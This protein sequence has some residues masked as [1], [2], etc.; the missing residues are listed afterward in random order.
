MSLIHE[1]TPALKG[2]L[3]QNDPKH[4]LDRVPD[5]FTQGRLQAE[6]H[7][8]NGSAFRGTQTRLHTAGA[9]SLNPTASERGAQIRNSYSTTRPIQRTVWWVRLHA[10]E[11]SSDVRGTV[12]FGYRVFSRIDLLARAA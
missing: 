9:C 2:G 1:I 3:V 8:V 12:L 7:Q 4:R 11:V 5:N 10:A 6:I